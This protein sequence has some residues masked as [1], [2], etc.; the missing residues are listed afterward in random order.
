M[1]L[2]VEDDENDAR[3][4][5][6]LCEKAGYAGRVQVAPTLTDA[7]HIAALTPPTAYLVDLCLPDGNGFELVHWLRESCSAPFAIVTSTL[8]AVNAAR[9]LGGDFLAKPFEPEDVARVLAWFES[10][11]GGP[12]SGP[13]SA[14]G[15][16][17]SRRT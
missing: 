13:R 15:P 3:D 2:I 16:A 7:T 14:P 9:R 8:C 10:E 4:L 5:R 17:G 11:S 1:L 6:E 12:I